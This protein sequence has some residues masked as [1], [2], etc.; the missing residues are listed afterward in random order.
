MRQHER[1]FT[2]DGEV[3]QATE[4]GPDAPGRPEAVVVLHGA[5]SSGRAR[6]LPLVGDFA[7]AGH[8]A[9]AFD[10]SGH[11]DSTGT[12]G[13]LSLERRFVQAR[14]V[15]REFAGTGPVVLVGFSMSGQTVAD[16]VGALGGQVSAVVLAAPAAYA[17]EAW[18][19]PFDH[20]FTEVLRRPDSWQHS[21]AYGL[22]AGFPGRAVLVVPER[23]EVI[24]PGVTSRIEDAL[25]QRADFARL[26]FP[27]STHRLG[28]WL[29]EHPED[30]A[31]LVR[32]VHT[33]RAAPA[34]R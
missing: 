20:G 22:L 12:L 24:P 18:K 32:T 16:L 17:P 29:A 27:G 28:S 7:R 23:D 13:A 26:T 4:A 8:R 14:H 25:R 15:V 30:R 21:N 5:G 3:L 11:G 6:N 34:G 33:V 31:R 1:T 9:L 19:L 2:V 10:F